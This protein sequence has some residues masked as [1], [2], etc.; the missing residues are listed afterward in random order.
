MTAETRSSRKRRVGAL[1]LVFGV[2][3]AGATGVSRAA[4]TQAEVDSAQER[5]HALEKD[6]ELA[7]EEYNLVHERLDQ[8]RKDIAT[9]EL[10]VRRLERHMSI[11]Q[12][13]AVALV[14]KRTRPPCGPS[15]ALLQLI[16]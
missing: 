13:S 7:V 8:I 14:E 9:G 12:D 4:P 11:E 16:I 1:L 2:M 5:L 6:F 3:G 10:V 15:F